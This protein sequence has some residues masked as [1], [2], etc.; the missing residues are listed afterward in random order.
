[1]K[2]VF[3]L[4]SMILLLLPGSVHAQHL[5]SLAAESLQQ[6]QTAAGTLAS[7]VNQVVLRAG[8][9]VDVEVAYTVNSKDV[10]VGESISFRVLIPITINGITVVQEKALVN[11]RIVEAK[12]NGHWG[13]PGRFS[14]VMEDVIAA[15]GTRIPVEAEA[16]AVRDKTNILKTVQK[17]T[18]SDVG[19]R[20]RGTGHGG[21]V[22]T[23]AVIAGALFPPLAPLGLL[24]GF[25]RGENAVLPEGK[26]FVVFIRNDTQ[27]K[28]TPSP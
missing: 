11:A 28:V 2:W 18:K 1:M 19:N 3:P 23:K 9:S 16:M 6:S 22:A 10:Q 27:I 20:V 4:V 5:S 26:R 21:E 15:D 12:R 14:W 13:R 24:Q 8:T 17:T 7:K 25:K